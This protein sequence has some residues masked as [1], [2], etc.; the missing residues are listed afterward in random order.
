MDL[1]T[2]RLFRWEDLPRERVTDQIG[3]KVITGERVMMAHIW[4]D[5]GCVVPHHSHESEQVSW[6]FSGALKFII[7]GET[8]VVRAGEVL[9]IPSWVAHEAVALEPTYEMD[10]FSPIRRDW[11][12][13]TDAYFHQP[14]TRAADFDNPATGGNPARLTRWD[15]VPVEPMTPSITRAFVT[16]ERATVAE[17]VLEAGTVVPTHEHESEQLTWV[18]SGALELEL[19]GEC[20][21]VSPDTVLRIPSRVP[22]QARALEPTRVVDVFGPRREDWLARD[23]QYLRRAEAR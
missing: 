21:T 16:G 7:G 11:L 18:R 19:A 4:L 6:V 17:L 10:V 15:T 2:P 9:V 8:Q 14:A 12:E 5:P 23:D 13:R 22:H 1:G 3:R 20:F